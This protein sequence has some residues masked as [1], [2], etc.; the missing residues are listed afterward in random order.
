MKI[1]VIEDDRRVA[2]TLK[3]L[4]T[5]QTYA[6]DVAADGKT[7]LQMIGI[8][9]YD[10]VVLDI[11]LPDIDGIHLCKQLRADGYELPILLLTGLDNSHEKAAGL[12]AGA[13]DYVAKPF[14]SE[15]L[16]ARVNALSRRRLPL[17][18]CILSWEQLTL[19]P[20]CYEAAYQGQVL[21]LTPKEFAILELFLRNPQR[22][23]S[24][25]TIVD[26]AWPSEEAPGEEVVRV[27]IKGLRQ[28]LKAAGAAP[29]LIE[30]VHRVGYRLNPNASDGSH[31]DTSVPSAPSASAVMVISR[32]SATVQLV[33]HLLQPQGLKVSALG[34]PKQL[35]SALTKQAASLIIIDIETTGAEG[36][37]LCHQL[38]QNSQWSQI[39]IITI[40]PADQPESIAKAFES[41]AN[42]IVRQPIIGPELSN[43]TISW[44]KHCSAAQKP[45]SLLSA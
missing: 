10:L 39:P 16:I 40:L 11:L 8:Y 26:Q 24:A 23:F 1:L 27:H 37:D 7:G 42:D 17:N 34:K 25:K 36:F 15:E 21:P 29:D 4:F 2:E 12:N 33:E 28:K 35:W 31:P 18:S 20:T 43:R 38:R 45:L 22:L 32:S 9:D 19:D 6:T 41:G 3:L 13:D 5:S 44:L 14:D 30:T